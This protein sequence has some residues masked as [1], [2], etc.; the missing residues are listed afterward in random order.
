MAAEGE[1]ARRVRLLPIIASGTGPP[2][3]TAL[4][5]QKRQLQPRA[6]CRMPSH[7]CPHLPSQP[8]VQLREAQVVANRQA[9]PPG[10]A[11]ADR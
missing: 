9:Q 4:Q 1:H 8:L 11:V 2:T 10:R 5:P 6:D 7:L 3:P